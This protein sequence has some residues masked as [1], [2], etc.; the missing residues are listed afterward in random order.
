MQV[1]PYIMSAISI[2]MNVDANDSC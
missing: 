2:L 1:L